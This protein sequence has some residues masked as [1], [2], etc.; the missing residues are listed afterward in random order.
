MF[1]TLDWYI[2]KKYLS[3][4]FFVVLIFSM[5][6]IVI[7]FSEKIDNFLDAKAPTNEIIWDYYTTF[8]PFIHGLLFPIYA[9]IA[10]IFF[11]SRMAYNSEIIAMLAGGISFRRLML[12][13]LIG[14][15][16]IAA[17][18]FALGHIVIPYGNKTKVAFENKYIMKYDG[19]TKRDNIHIYLTP[20]TKVYIRHYSIT[21]TIAR[22]VILE[23]I[24]DGELVSKLTAKRAKYSGA[25]GKWKLT[26]YD[27]RTFKGK[28]ETYQ[29]GVDL[30]TLINLT[31]YDIERRDNLKS[32]MTS[33][34][35]ANFLVSEKKRGTGKA[36]L[37]EIE[38]YNRTAAPFTIIILTFIG[39]IVAAR[40]V[41]GGTG[42]H[43]AIGAGL[44]ALYIMFNQVSTTL[45]TNANFHPL[46]GVWTPNIVF[47]I[48][49]ILLLRNA[50]K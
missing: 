14:G 36:I 19:E 49:T 50:Q 11:T 33:P 41:R 4:F 30:D 24:K 17:I 29:T 18:Y 21:D 22:D 31:P 47:I 46:L 15:T 10:V 35:L 39:M 27:I 20:E 37:F 9:L 25:T 1:K 23:E 48:V 2:I 34:E 43:L 8:I 26:N 28:K 45:S 3:T 40:K 42:L 7:D 16:I 6:T 13:Y 44:G 5:I 12:P 32:T 38:L